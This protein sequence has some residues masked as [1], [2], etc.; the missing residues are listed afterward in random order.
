VLTFPI[1]EE[2]RNIKHKRRCRVNVVTNAWEAIGQEDGIVRIAVHPGEGDRLFTG[3]NPCGASPAG[4]PWVALDVADSG[5]GMDIETQG[6]I[7]DPFFSTKF[8]GRGLG[9]AVTLGIVRACNGAIFVESELHRGTTVRVLLPAGEALGGRTRDKE[10]RVRGGVGACGSGAAERGR[11]CETVTRGTEGCEKE[12]GKRRERE[13]VLLVDD[14]DMVRDLGQAMLE[15]LGFD[16]L[17]ARSGREAV[18]VFRAQSGALCCVILDL[19]MPGMDGWQTLRAL[20]ELRP[21][22]RAV[23]AT[24]YDVDQLQRQSGTLQPHR[25]LQKPY[26][27]TELKAVLQQLQSDVSDREGR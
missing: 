16:V 13:T 25:W 22:V 14:Q 21:D 5:V 6:R 18:E 15:R 1:K 2:K 7:F 10:M 20:R 23:L 4:G 26:E 17:T 3:F 27:Y 8:T 24:G 11:H 9:L 12:T 19:T